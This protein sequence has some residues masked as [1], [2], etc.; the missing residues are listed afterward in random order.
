MIRLRQWICGIFLG[1]RVY[2]RI[3]CFGDA[4]FRGGLNSRR[5]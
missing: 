4:G 2:Y 1:P 5:G 3:A